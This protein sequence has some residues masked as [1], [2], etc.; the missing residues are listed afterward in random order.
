[1]KMNSPHSDGL[2]SHKIHIQKIAF[3][4]LWNGKIIIQDNK[5]KNQLQLNDAMT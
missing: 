1:M 3:G 5:Q 4:L 2:N